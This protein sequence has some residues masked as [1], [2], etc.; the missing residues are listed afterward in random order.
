MTTT[1]NMGLVLPD[2]HASTDVWGALLNAISTR[3]DLH[4]H[5]TGLG[6]KVPAAGLDINADVSWA[7]G[8]TSHAITDLTAIDFKPG[9]VPT[10]LAA[11][12]FVSDGTSGLSANELYFRSTAGTNIKVTAGS[13]LNVA[14]FTGGIGGDY[15]SV[16][17]L[18]IFDDATDS[19]WFQQ[20]VGSAVRQYAR[21]RSADLDLFEFKANPAA[22]VPTNRVRLKSPAALAASYDLTWM[23]ALHTAGTRPMTVT[24]AGVIGASADP[25]VFNFGLATAISG[26][27]VITSLGFALGTA[28]AVHC[29]CVHTVNQ[30]ASSWSVFINKIS[31]AGTTCTANFIE[32]DTTTGAATTISSNSSAVAGATK[33]TLTNNLAGISNVLAAGKTYHLTVAESGPGS[34]DVVYSWSINP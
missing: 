12:F 30:N 21:L 13:A 33:V 3:I 16:G 1:P 9:A 6:V 34:G 23:A 11:A 17:A 5:T 15:A 20:Q 31:G 24:S 22:G 7:S 2:D 18:E 25:I 10:A 29:P 32:V 8:G 19:Y 26:S 27:P 14:A 4:S 28:S